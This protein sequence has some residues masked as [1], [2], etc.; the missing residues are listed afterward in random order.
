MTQRNPRGRRRLLAAMAD[1]CGC[2]HMNGLSS[3]KKKPHV[4]MCILKTWCNGWTT[5]ERMHHGD[6]RTCIWG[7][8]G[9]QDSLQH[10]I[11]CNRL[12]NPIFICL[13]LQQTEDILQW[14]AIMNVCE[15]RLFSAV[16]VAFVAYHSK[17]GAQSPIPPT[18]INEAVKAAMLWLS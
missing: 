13:R 18:K 11:Q 16:A 5:S 8:V 14:R 7:C 6:K 9:E 4:R 15:L 2:C 1:E 10:Y 3:M 12:W 17:R